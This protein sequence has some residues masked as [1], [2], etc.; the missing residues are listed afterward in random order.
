MTIQ[1]EYLFLFRSARFFALNELDVRVDRALKD[2]NETAM[3]DERALRRLLLD[4]PATVMSEDRS[5]LIAQWLSSFPPL[6]DWFVNPPEPL[7][8]S[9]LIIE[10]VI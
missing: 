7:P 10:S 8:S 1:S 6:P 9:H 2:E 3:T 4:F 5:T